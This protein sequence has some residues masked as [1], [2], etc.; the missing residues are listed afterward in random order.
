MPD[1]IKGLRSSASTHKCAETVFQNESIRTNFNDANLRG[2]IINHVQMHYVDFS[3][4]NLT[5]IEA[6][7]I[8]LRDCKFIGTKLNHSEMKDAT[9]FYSDFTNAE[10][11]NSQFTQT[12][13]FQDVSFH[14]AKIIDGYFEK[15]IFI[16]TDFSGADLKGSMINDAHMIGN[17]DLR[18]KNHQIC[19]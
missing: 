14:N 8:A 13:F 12:S 6:L 4:A 3:G 2:A 17:I 11:E 7:D 18:C 10:L 1:Y 9:F 5:G 15:P 16:D 19:D